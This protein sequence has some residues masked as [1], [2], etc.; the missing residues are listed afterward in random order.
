[1][2]K[3]I[4]SFEQIHPPKQGTAFQVF[5]NEFSIEDIK[6]L[7]RNL[8]QF[9]SEIDCLLVYPLPS[10]HSP[11]KNNALSIFYPGESCVRFGFKIDYWDGRFDKEEELFEKLKKTNIVA[12]SSL[13][14]FQLSETIRLAQKI[15]KIN[16]DTKIILGGVHATF[17]PE[18]CLNE[19]YIDYVVLGEGE[20]R[21]PALLATILFDEFES[22]YLE[23]IDG[24]GWKEFT[25]W[26]IPDRPTIYINPRKHTINLN[27]D[28]V[29]C[30][31][32]Q[33]AKY[34]QTSAARNE[35]ILQTSRGCNWSPTSCTFCSVGGQW[36]NSFRFIPFELWKADMDKILAFQKFDFIEL[37]D[38][39]SSFFIKKMDL[40]A[41][42][43]N[44]KNIKYHLHLRADQLQDETT[45]RHLAETGCIRIH[46]GV[47]SGNERVLNQVLHKNTDI[48]KYYSCAKLLA[49]YGIEGVYTYIIGN[50]SETWQEVLD[51]L[52]LSDDLAEIHGPGFSRA[53]IYV[54]ICLPGTPIFDEVKKIPGWKIPQTMQEWANVSAAYNPQVEEAY[55]NIYFIGGIHHN[56]HHKTKQNFPGLWRL[57]IKPF[58]MLCDL[59]WKLALKTKKLIFFKFFGLE[60]WIISKLI[61]WRAQRSTGQHVS[62]EHQA[63]ILE[64]YSEG[65]AGH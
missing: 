20:L 52:K 61:S 49:K 17:S 51:T 58:E 59:R 34:F 9:Y 29:S 21:L 16:K 60:K 15:K 22:K 44:D 24:I 54:L 3:R 64:E 43:L 36:N 48:K 13:S 10:P 56:K 63:K 45:I 42:Y 53:T 19:N 27:E 50:P 40:Y 35:I 57:L 46:V 14:G 39:N 41:K 4:S 33:T 47:E 30:V 37:E 31:S 28:Y 25:D 65:L 6:E 62:K 5:P 8:P 55:N 32:E 11:Q 23:R 18:T 38:E 2:L 7:K 12:F 26:E 1:M